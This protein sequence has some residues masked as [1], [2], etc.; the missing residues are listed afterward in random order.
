[1]KASNGA[2]APINDLQFIHDRMDY[3]KVDKAVADTVIDKLGHHGWCLSEEVVPFAMFSKNAKMINSKY[4][5][6]L[7]ARLLETPEPDNFR[8]GKPLFR[9]VARDTT[10]KDLIGP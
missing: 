7:A 4:D 3:R 9:K 5:Q 6:Q 10:L 8:L 1:M 2:D